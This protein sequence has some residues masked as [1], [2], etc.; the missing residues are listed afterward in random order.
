VF[1]PVELSLCA[2]LIDC[3]W[4][5]D[6]GPIAELSDALSESSAIT[7]HMKKAA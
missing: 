3:F 1:R 2:G 7:L 6:F 5:F 4:P